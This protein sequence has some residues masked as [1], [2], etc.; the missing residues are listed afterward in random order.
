VYVVQRD[1]MKEAEDYL[2][3]NAVTHGDD[4]GTQNIIDVLGVQT[5]I[6]SPEQAEAFKFHFKAGWGGYPLVGTPERIVDTLQTMSGIGLDGVS[7]IWVDYTDG[8]ARWE[9][10]VMPLL[11]QSGLRQ[12]FAKAA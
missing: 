7:L 4:R 6:W 12:G 1:T 3:Y 11:E 8:I 2:H 10:S 5:G 9:K